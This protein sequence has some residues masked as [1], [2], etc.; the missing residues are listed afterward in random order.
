MV[1]PKED[2]PEPWLPAL[3]SFS[4]LRTSLH[5]ISKTKSVEALP[6]QAKFSSH[7]HHGGQFW[8]NYKDFAVRVEKWT[9]ESGS[10]LVFAGNL[11]FYVQ[12]NGWISVWCDKF[13]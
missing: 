1:Y 8:R 12:L 5:I 2:S 6:S 13:P 11:A 3:E 7:H 4:G 9:S 10:L